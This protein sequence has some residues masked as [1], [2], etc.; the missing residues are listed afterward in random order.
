MYLDDKTPPNPIPRA[1]IDAGEVPCLLLV[2]GDP[3]GKVY[4]L[5]EGPI[6]LGRE[7]GNGILLDDPSVS[8][9]H[10]RI[11]RPP[12]EETMLVTDL[13]S[14]NGTLLN[15]R[16][17]TEHPLRQGDLL[18]I[19]V[20]T[21]KVTR[22]DP[23]QLRYL[24]KIEE[25]IQYDELTGLFTVKTVLGYTEKEIL[26]SKRY[27]RDFSLLIFDID[28]FK[29]V[30]DTYGHVAGSALL[31]ELGGLVARSVRQGIDRPGRYGG[32]EF[33][34]L[35]PETAKRNGF[36]AA[37]RL[38]EKIAAHT[39]LCDGHAIEITVSLGLASFG[40]DHESGGNALSLLK[41]AD[42]AL[43][44]AKE[45]GRNRTKYIVRFSATT[46]TLRR[47]K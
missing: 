33:L 29:R 41:K 43:Y 1:V 31:K 2:G 35:L 22:C 46:A 4:P 14:T 47:R 6:S 10:A 16:K 15:G 26:R 21:F 18:Q 8:R 23:L 39:F 37:E 45:E 30:N 40:E 5:E 3:V 20:Y 9:R 7:P 27:G 25:Q 44:R 13:G 19:G 17:I 36:L 28:H 42:H 38:R 34:L 12:G 11:D 32:D 24:Q